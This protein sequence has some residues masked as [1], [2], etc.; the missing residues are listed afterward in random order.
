M[1]PVLVSPFLDKVTKIMHPGGFF[2]DPEV[3]RWLS[4]SSNLQGRSLNW[5]IPVLY[6]PYTFRL[7]HKPYRDIYLFIY[8]GNVFSIH[9]SSLIKLSISFFY[10]CS[11]CCCR[12]RLLFCVYVPDEMIYW[13]FILVFWW[14]SFFLGLMGL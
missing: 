14:N 4:C 11:E 9:V 1:C 12:Y 13:A 2:S 3:S 8:W 5:Y 10:F 7:Y 6:D